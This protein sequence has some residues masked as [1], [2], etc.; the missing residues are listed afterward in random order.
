MITITL[1]DGVIFF[2]DEEITEAKEMTRAGAPSIA[3]KAAGTG[4]LQFVKTYR[5]EE[6][7]DTALKAIQAETDRK[8]AKETLEKRKQETDKYLDQARQRDQSKAAKSRKAKTEKK[9]K[10]ETYIKPPTG[11]EII[12]QIKKMGYDKKLDVPADII[13]DAFVAVYETTEPTG[14]TDERGFA[15]FKWKLAN[16]KPVR[17][18]RGCLRTYIGREQM[19]KASRKTETRTKRQNQF[20]RGV[21][22][23]EYNWEELE[24]ELYEQQL[25]ESSPV[26]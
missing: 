21:E 14:E 16:G 17:D 6:E 10:E 7:R 3:F 12:S 23:N 18:W 4:G 5:T 13:A 19:H 26:D 25:S 11:E 2:P 22:N 1:P 20:T 9:K 24:R 8:S 15:I